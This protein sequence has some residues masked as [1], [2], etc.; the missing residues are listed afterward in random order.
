MKNRVFK[1]CVYVSL[2]LFLAFAG[3]FCCVELVGSNP[4][5]NES[6]VRW[7]FISVGSLHVAATK[8]FGGNLVFFNQPSPYLGSV[9]G[10]EGAKT[11]T[12]E[13]GCDLLG[14]HFRMFYSTGAKTNEELWTLMVSL[15]YPIVLFAIIPAVFLMREKVWPTLHPPMEKPVRHTEAIPKN[16]QV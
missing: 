1:A 9:V 13:T 7:K 16:S 14:I 10:F 5:L 11:N 6:G 15:W 4:Q 3:V 8:L 2:F 12:A